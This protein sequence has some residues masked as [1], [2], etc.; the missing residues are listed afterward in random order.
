[1]KD[2]AVYWYPSTYAHEHGELELYRTSQKANLACKE[3]I[4]AAISEN[5]RDNC[6]NTDAVKQVM[7]GRA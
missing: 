2:I 4:E 7:A 6:L 5:Y 3:A 1:M